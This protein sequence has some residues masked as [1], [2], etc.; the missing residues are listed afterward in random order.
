MQQN[1]GS[2]KQ[3]SSGGSR[4]KQSLVQTGC[5]RL[6]KTAAALRNSSS[7]ESEDPETAAEKLRLEQLLFKEG[8]SSKSSSD[9]DSSSDGGSDSELDSAAGSSSRG[10]AAAAASS[11]R[12]S[13]SSAASG[14]VAAEASTGKP[15]QPP[16][17]PTP[18]KGGDKPSSSKGKPV[19]KSD[20]T[21]SAADKEKAAKASY[22]FKSSRWIRMAKVLL[23]GGADPLAP[24]TP[25]AQGLAA[26]MMAGLRGIVRGN[27][28]TAF[29]RLVLFEPKDYQ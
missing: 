18:D 13:I 16:M 7:D 17:S 26:Q 28:T 11:S 9:S 27:T 12:A 1:A 3:Q 14:S 24:V 5:R 19:S 4:A 21:E 23:A 15:A 22:G 2:A 8:P 25:S 29:D 6:K 10:M 20:A